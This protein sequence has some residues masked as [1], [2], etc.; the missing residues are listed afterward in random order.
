VQESI[1]HLT[2]QV[3]LVAD[4]LGYRDTPCP[5]VCSGGLFQSPPFFG[6]VRRALSGPPG[7][8]C[9][10]PD[11]S[12]AEGAALLAWHARALAEGPREGS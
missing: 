1:D 8:D 4:R 12:P 9:V 3:R 2:G 7:F 6:A 5:V 11:R 10:R